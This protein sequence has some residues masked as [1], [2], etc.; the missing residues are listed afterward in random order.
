MKGSSFSMS[1]KGTPARRSTPGRG[2]SGN[3]SLTQ[4]QGGYQ[5]RYGQ[6]SGRQ[7]SAGSNRGSGN[8]NGLGLDVSRMVKVQR[9]PQAAPSQ[10]QP[11]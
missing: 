8:A 3:A 10:A 6:S 7:S 2:G 9:A 4:S 5:P 1:V 11:Q